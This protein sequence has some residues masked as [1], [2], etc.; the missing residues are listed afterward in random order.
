MAR[1]EQDVA[2]IA[3]KIADR[4]MGKCTDNFYKKDELK[5]VNQ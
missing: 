3:F 2:E 1:Y 4:F 5:G